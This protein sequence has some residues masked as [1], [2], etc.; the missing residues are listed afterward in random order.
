VGDRLAFA[1]FCGGLRA[2]L[3]GVQKAMFPRPV[4]SEIIR[5][6]VLQDPS[7]MT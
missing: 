4:L 2:M 5:A 1:V 6:V 7:I 3:A